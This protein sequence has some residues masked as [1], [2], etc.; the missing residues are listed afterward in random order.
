MKTKISVLLL[1]L[2]AI[3]GLAH[4]A[5]ANVLTS[6]LNGNSIPD[7]EEP[8]VI[9]STSQFLNAGEYNFQN[10]TITN[11]STLT[12]KG[13]SLSPLVFKGVKINANNLTVDSGSNISANGQGYGSDGPGY[14]PSFTSQI[15]A[16]SYGGKGGG[17]TDA[18]I[19]GSSLN[20]T[21]LGSGMGPGA[22]GGGAIWLNISS[23]LTNNGTISANYGA[24]RVSGGSIYLQTNTITGIGSISAS[25]G[26]TSWPY[27]SYAGGGGRI[28]VYYNTNTY[29]GVVTASGGMSCFS[30]CEKAGG[31]GT[32]A[33]IDTNDNNLYI[34]S[35][36]RFQ[37]ND[38]FNFNTITMETSSRANTDPGVTI[39]ANT[40]ALQSLSILTLQ[41]SSTLN[42]STITLSGNALMY[43]SGTDTLNVNT[44]N[45]Q[46]YSTIS[47][48][49]KLVK[50][51]LDI[52]NITISANASILANTKGY[53]LYQGL[54]A[55]SATS[56]SEIIPLYAGASYGGR[57]QYSTP[58]S[59]YGSEREPTDFGSG[60]SSGDSS[61][62]GGGGAIR[63]DTQNLTLDGTISANGSR[64]SSG[65]S[66]Y[67]TTKN[68]TGTGTVEAK[69]GSDYC[70]SVCYYGYGGGGRIALYYSTSTF[71]GTIS[72]IGGNTCTSGCTADDGT[73]V[74]EQTGCQI[75]C[76]SNVLF[77][78]GIQGS[79]LYETKLIGSGLV[80]D[81]LWEPNNNIDI[82]ELYLNTDGSSVDPNIYTR[83]MI[84]RTNIGILDKD[85]YKSFA[86]KMDELVTQ[87]K[88][89]EW[90][91]FAYDWRQDVADVAEN[92][93]Q[94]GEGI[95]KLKDILT[96]LSNNSK[97]NGKVT[98]VAHSNGGLL[99]KAFLKYLQEE[100]DAGNSDLIDK[101][102]VLVLVAT[103]QI[104]TPD[105]ML[106]IFHG[107]SLG[108]GLIMD[109][110]RS[111]LF[112]RNMLGAYGLLPS[113]EYINHVSAS[114][115][116]F[117][118]TVVPSNTMTNFIQSYGNVVDSYD[119]YKSFLFGGEG[120]VEPE[121]SD[122][123]SP[124]KLL[125]SLFQ[126]SE[127]LHDA[128]DS[129]TPPPGMRVVQIAGWG[130]DTLATIQY[131][132]RRSC[133]SIT[134]CT[135]I[136]DQTPVFTANGD[137]TVVGPSAHYMGANSS[138]EK[139]WLDLLY[140]N[141]N[142][143]DRAHDSILEVS[144]LL[145]F[146]E[147]LVQNQT[148]TDSMITT[149]KPIDVSNRLRISLLSPVS[150]DA[151]DSFGNHTGKV[152][153]PSSDFCFAEENISNSSYW[154]IGEGKYINIPEANMGKI[155]LQ[156]TDIGTFTYKSEKV[157]PD[158][159]SIVSSFVD[160]PVTT[161]TQVEITLNQT[162][163]APELKLDVTGD[164]V[165]DFTLT[166]NDTFD[167]ITYLEV[168]KAT[169]NS[170]DIAQAK[171]N[172]FSKR[173]DN[174]IKSIQKGK[175]DKAKLKAEKFKDVLEKKLAKPDPKH[176]KPKKLSKTDAQLLLDML[177]KLLDNL[178]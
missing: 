121:P 162:T 138:V 105:A 117:K 131:Q 62:S 146:I 116:V 152:C 69:G 82:E 33:F 20:P 1:F 14:T 156:G 177:N 95:R 165:S 150:V 53:E 7:H 145:T 79:R 17:N 34:K 151:Y 122:I 39:S 137:K 74:Y 107:M 133:V 68:L 113:R 76:N 92:G 16:S 5:K 167:P 30:G 6:D 160:I 10:L 27:L 59:V 114:P 164:G 12:L 176:P 45:L 170:L 88:I 153:P 35:Y 65:G 149:T 135:D 108:E 173:V 142:N 168:M 52:P 148:L 2:V 123:Y 172:A 21:Q 47:I 8:E 143:P 24:E 93:T 163:Q 31:D 70:P 127:A 129:W 120:R 9:V 112:A 154:E 111:R 134:N 109:K 19:Y 147:N 110:T 99:A 115:V 102:D 37:N 103:P 155:K 77:L 51:T 72:A 126:K 63:I 75:N 169:V 85:I 84:E 157:L 11:N 73:V 42:I 136:L 86:A 50:L 97:N 54:G 171:K 43:L 140:Y 87:E 104:G 58:G 161:Q 144:N 32:V 175:I 81:Q 56:I 106:S 4:I 125:P 159:T 94:Y 96:V 40:L 90:Q 55:P 98:I 80:E 130:I 91:S 139:Y 22:K 15:I 48:T 49:P 158:G 36:F 44:L 26:N 3:L 60:G 64:T 119:E 61:S 124:I 46:D 100:K 13:D 89:N 18:S 67:I 128:I 29:T 132:P 66:I 57:G 28:A 38:T 71:T 101:V 174:I 78:P 41:N 25:G 23:T 178:E 141:I 166:P 118:D 83:E